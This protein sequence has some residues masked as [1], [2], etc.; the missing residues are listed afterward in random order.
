[1]FTDVCRPPPQEP[2]GAPLEIDQG[3]TIKGKIS[4]EEV[5][6]LAAFCLSVRPPPAL[7]TPPDS[8]GGLPACGA[9][10]LLYSLVTSAG[11]VGPVRGFQAHRGRVGRQRMVQ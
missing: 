4:R 6:D 1:M 2:E 11:C 3:D 5:A 7:R 8:H 9:H 10:S